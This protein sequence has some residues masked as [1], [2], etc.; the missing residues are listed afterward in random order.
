[1]IRANRASLSI[2]NDVLNVAEITAQLRSE[3]TDAGDIGEVTRAGRAGRDL[4]PELRTRHRTF[5]SITETDDGENDD[6]TGAAA[7]RILV[8]RLKPH[9]DA[10]AKMRQNG[11]T[12]IWWSGGSDSAQGGFVLDADLI[13]GLAVLGCAVYGTAYHW[14]VEAGRVTEA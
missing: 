1:V 4:R 8:D 3:P 13:A 12:V 5:W 7:L 10:L 6:R 14:H 2:H 11:E 9:A